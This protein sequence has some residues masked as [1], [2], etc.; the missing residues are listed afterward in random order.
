VGNQQQLRTRPPRAHGAIC[1]KL[2][3]A[4][5][6]QNTPSS[7]GVCVGRAASGEALSSEPPHA[8]RSQPEFIRK[9]EKNV[10][11]HKFSGSAC[12][13]LLREKTK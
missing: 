1:S 3:R 11:F 5:F 2:R 9:V 7:M 13:S 12:S 8:T 4:K 6:F 10:V